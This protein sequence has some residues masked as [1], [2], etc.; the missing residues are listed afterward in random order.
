MT[1]L[2]VS[3]ALP[4]G[5]GLITLIG[6]VT[7]GGCGDPARHR[8]GV[9]GIRVVLEDGSYGIEAVPGVI[10]FGNKASGNGNPQQCLNVTCT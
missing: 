8:K 2:T 7:E 6:R 3:E 5:Y 9:G 1:R 4:A 10:A